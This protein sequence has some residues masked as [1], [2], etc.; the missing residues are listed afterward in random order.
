MRAVV[1]VGTDHKFQRPMNGA[2]VAEVE[3]FR[4]AIRDL[5]IRHKVHAIAEEMNPQACR[6]TKLE[7]Q[8]LINYV[9]S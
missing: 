3:S 4:N 6:N 7:S 8:F 9:V 1:L 5:C 2:G